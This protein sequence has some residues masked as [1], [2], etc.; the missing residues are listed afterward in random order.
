M[1]QTVY[2][3]PAEADVNVTFTLPGTQPANAV[4]RVVNNLGQPITH[5]FEGVLE[6]GSHTMSWNGRD[7]HGIRP[8]QGLYLVE[9]LSN[10]QRTAKRVVL[11]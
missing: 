9:V 1:I 6:A 2:P 7:V 3:N 10:G 5:L 4:V 8:A 11:K